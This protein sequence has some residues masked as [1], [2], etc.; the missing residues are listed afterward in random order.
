MTSV[1]E[2]LPLTDR[3][4]EVYDFIRWH[5]EEWHRPPT[6]REMIDAF[7]LSGPS[8]MVCH[9]T[10]LTKKGWIEHDQNASNGIRLT[11]V[12]LTI[13]DIE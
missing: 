8:A 3:Q 10:A 13:E 9:L 7:D 2:R 6:Y 1:D 4:R 12:K 5:I 11:G